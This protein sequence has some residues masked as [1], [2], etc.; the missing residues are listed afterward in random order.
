MRHILVFL[1]CVTASHACTCAP[2]SSLE[3]EFC[4]SDFGEIVS[5]VNVT[6]RIEPNST[7]FQF[8]YIY[9]VQ[10]IRIYRNPSNTTELSDRCYNRAPVG[11]LVG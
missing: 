1:A 3:E 11:S 10:H 8:F 2:F 9:S 5:H 6:G 7:D 4:F